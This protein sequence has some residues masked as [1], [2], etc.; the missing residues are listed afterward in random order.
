MSSEALRPANNR[1]KHKPQSYM[2]LTMTAALNSN[3]PKTQVGCVLVEKD[4]HISSIGYYAF[5][6]G[7]A[8]R[9]DETVMTERKDLAIIH[10]EANA[11]HHCKELA[12]LKNAGVHV[13]L[14]SCSVSA[15][16][17]VHAQVSLVIYWSYRRPDEENPMRMIEKREELKIG[18]D[19]V[20]QKN[21]AS[22]FLGS[23]GRH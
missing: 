11:T 16:M 19:E 4:K 13:T 22:S 20:C 7:L 21:D 2:H 6:Y 9:D 10:A 1:T 5:P 14:H 23:S 3:D 18:R 8:D 12:R 17:L 15:K